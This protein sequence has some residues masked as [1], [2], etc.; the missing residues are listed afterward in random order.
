MAKHSMLT[1]SDASKLIKSLVNRSV[2]LS[3]DIQRAACSAIG[4]ANVHG[5]TNVANELLSV[6]TG[7]LRRDAIVKYLEHFGCVKYDAKAKTFAHIKRADTEVERD[8]AKLMVKLYE[9]TWDTFTAEK[10]TSAYDFDSAV[11]SAI[12][13]AKARAEKKLDVKGM[14]HLQAIELILDGA[15]VTV[16]DE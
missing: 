14:E 10:V 15:E 8:P 6:F 13:T 11:R 3:T 12:K 4:Q 1:A 2:K 9:K 5:N 7:G 16:R